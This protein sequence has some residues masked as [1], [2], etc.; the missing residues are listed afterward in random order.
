MIKQRS[1][2][3]PATIIIPNGDSSFQGLGGWLDDQLAKVTTSVES[4]ARNLGQEYLPKEVYEKAHNYAT[5][6]S[7]C[8]SFK[9]NCY[10]S[11]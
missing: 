6:W 7:S 9:I 10:R 3:S 1:S 11:S 8:R 5:K 4:Q 2:N